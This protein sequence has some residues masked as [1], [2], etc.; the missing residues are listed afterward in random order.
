LEDL[1]PCGTG[2]R[3][4]NCC[5]TKSFEW[6]A[7][8]EGGWDRS[9]PI[10]PEHRPHFDAIVGRFKAI[11]RR[12][13]LPHDNPA[14]ETYVMSA[15]DFMDA[16][17]VAAGRADVG[18]D[19]AF[20]YAM[21]KTGSIV[22]SE[23]RH[24]VPEKRLE[25]WDKAI[26]EYQRTR[27]QPVPDDLT[28]V[29]ELKRQLDEEFERLPYIL[30]KMVKD[31]AATHPRFLKGVAQFQRGFVFFA[32]ARTAKTVRALKHLIGDN[33]GEDALSLVRS[34]YENYLHMV[35]AVLAPG[36]LKRLADAQVGLVIGTHRNP[37]NSRGKPNRR[38][39]EDPS[40]GQRVRADVT[41]LELAQQSPFPQDVLVHRLL[42]SFLSRY[43]HP[44]V[45]TVA[46]YMDAER[47]YS[48]TGR[49]TVFEAFMLALTVS[50]L[51]L[52]AMLQVRPLHDSCRRDAVTFL[53]HLRSKLVQAHG[54]EDDKS[55]MM[56]ALK[57]R[58][59]AMGRSWPKSSVTL[60]ID[61]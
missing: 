30:G 5:R 31:C 32:V 57:E 56:E 10:K 4:E 29:A 11:F 51:V 53:S 7:D 12:D 50:G 23:L 6:V 33:L 41:T 36:L 1:C 42:Y 9:V 17:E 15:D 61:P 27:T 28:A 44:H 21:R 16:F 3:F 60:E 48:T 2:R 22:L 46:H 39:I 58:I 24:V 14:V 49:D 54:Y 8:G 55:D 34:I 18:L 52:D 59:A 19:P 35:I 47:G 38:I 26:A 20:F 25:E 13:P 43:T 37:L 40:N 45:R